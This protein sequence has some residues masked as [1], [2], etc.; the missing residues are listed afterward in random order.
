MNHGRSTAMSPTA[1]DDTPSDSAPAALP[2]AMCI[3]AK[4]APSLR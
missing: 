2:D 3:R 4:D 1:R